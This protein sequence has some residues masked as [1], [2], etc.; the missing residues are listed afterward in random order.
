MRVTIL[1]NLFPSSLAPRRAVFNLQKFEALSQLH[2]LQILVPIP[3]REWFRNGR[4]SATATFAENIRY[5]PYYYPPGLG[6][7]WYGDLL[8]ASVRSHLRSV[9]SFAPDLIYGSFLF[10][11]GYAAGRL[12]GELR[13]PRVVGLHGSDVNIHMNH[14]ARVTRIVRSLQLTN[15]VISVSAAL[16][17]RLL[18]AGV[19]PERIAT[20]YNGVDKRLF[21]PRP[22]I[23][24]RSA[25][26]LPAKKIVV[27]IG[28]LLRSKGV[29]DLASAAEKLSA[30]TSVIFIG[31][32]A[33]RN[34]LADRIRT[35]RTGARLELAG[36][37]PHGELPQWIAAAD[38]VCL[39]SYREGVPNVVLEAI[40]CGRPVVATDVGGIPEVTSTDNAVLVAP[41]AI[42][43]LS[44]ALQQALEQGWDAQ[45]LASSG[46]INSWSEVATQI[47]TVLQRA[48]DEGPL[49]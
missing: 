38:V 13:L 25:L 36:S 28:N 48:V 11:D 26:G 18:A 40:A 29:L 7:R 49:T 32:G 47:S 2:T 39:P 22:K 34:Q 10:P 31:D 21:Y 30:D 1:T 6:R 4:P 24:A 35:G 5:F 19:A 12:A 3:W 16:E 46:K 14:A 45:R 17:R 9:K 42:D 20:I 41:G 8:F 37:R 33:D 15:G 23:E 44:L 27:Y 43:A